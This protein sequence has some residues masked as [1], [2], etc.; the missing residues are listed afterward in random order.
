MDQE[1]TNAYVLGDWNRIMQVISNLLSNAIKFTSQGEVHFGFREKKDFIEFYVKDSGIGIPAE[2]AATIF[3][4]FGKINDFTQ[5]T[6]LGLPLCR[7]LVVKM[8]GR[9]WLRSE[10]DKGTT[11]YFTLPRI[12][13]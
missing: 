2:R 1:N 8:G 10:E 13:P 5:G 9:I 6:G 4:R 12:Q 7:M 11:F 3:Q